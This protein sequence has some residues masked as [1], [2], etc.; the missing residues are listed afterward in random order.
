MYSQHVHIYI[1][2]YVHTHTLTGET[3]VSELEHHQAGA[4]GRF[5]QDLEILIS[6]CPNA[7]EN[8]SYKGTTESTFETV[9]LEQLRLLIF[10]AQVLIRQV[11][12][13]RRIPAGA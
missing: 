12:L 13:Q 8:L 7:Q 1:Y 3:V 10:R 6:Q 9:D 2:A 5:S 4:G 11:Q